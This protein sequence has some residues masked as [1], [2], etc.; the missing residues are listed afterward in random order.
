MIRIFLNIILI[1]SIFILPVYVSVVLIFISVFLFK[2]FIEAIIFGFLIDTL[3]GSGTILGIHF[4][5]FFTAIIFI[6]FL[7]SFKF[8]KMLRTSFH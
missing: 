7:I 6:F 3:Y 8:K 4:A 2:N 5:Y 1:L